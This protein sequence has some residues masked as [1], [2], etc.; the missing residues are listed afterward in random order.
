MGA[1]A[2]GV[3]LGLLALGVYSFLPESTTKDTGLP[4]ESKLVVDAPVDAVLG[5][6]ELNDLVSCIDK[7]AVE[8]L[9]PQLSSDALM[10]K[11][12]QVCTNKLRGELA[13]D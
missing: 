9:D 10:A 4:G 8:Q 2:T 7:Y 13:Q 6:P 5:Q 11:A 3:M 1:L 12:Q